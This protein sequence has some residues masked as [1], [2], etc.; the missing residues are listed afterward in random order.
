M[1]KM[2]RHIGKLTQTDTRCI[3]VM[4]QIPGR[5]N[6][7]LILESDSLP[8]LYHQN[9]MQLLESKEGQ[10]N[11][12]FA[13]ELSKRSMFIANR[14]NIPVLTALHEARFLRAVPITNI[15]MTPTPGSAYPLTQVLEGMGID[16]GGEK[17]AL[18][19]KHD[20]NTIKFNPHTHN[21]DINTSDNKK[22]AARGLLT[23]ADFVAAE[24][25]KLRE[26]AY[27]L[28]PEFR[29]HHAKQQ[30]SEINNIQEAPV[31]KKRGRPTGSKKA[32]NN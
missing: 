10:S 4:M 25:N 17:T 24:A 6:H 15:V 5:E 9:V 11:M 19:P 18:D 27:T 12:S 21:Q 13:D 31:K 7:A 20:P 3:V 23:Q 14:G 8:D 29:P 16:L 1:T 30:T 2:M 26:Q 32:A 28:A 22:A